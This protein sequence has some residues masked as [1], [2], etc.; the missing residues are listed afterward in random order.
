M[1]HYQSSIKVNR[2][3]LITSRLLIHT[4]ILLS[5]SIN[6]LIQTGFVTRV[7]VDFFSIAIQYL[8]IFIKHENIFNKK[9]IPTLHEI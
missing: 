1:K 9:Y 8:M 5:N 2:I 7:R 6:A 3:R 4:K